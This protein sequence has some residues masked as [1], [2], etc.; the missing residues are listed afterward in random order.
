MQMHSLVRAETERFTVT[1]LHY[2]NNNEE[3]EEDGERD[4][5]E[6]VFCKLFAGV[7]LGQHEL[8]P[9]ALSEVVERL[10]AGHAVLLHDH[11]Q[12]LRHAALV[13]AVVLLALDQLLVDLEV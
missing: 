11:A 3:E 13:E 1:R 2:D 4:G 6:E 7:P 12:H 10:A 5:C 8:D 9:E